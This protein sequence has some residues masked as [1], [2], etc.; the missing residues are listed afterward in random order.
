[1]TLTLER[2]QQFKIT[3]PLWIY[4]GA[5][6]AWHFFTIPQ[7]ESAQIKF[8]AADVKRG[9]GSVRVQVRIGMTEWRT[10]IFP[11]SK[12]QTYILPVKA[13]VRKKESLAEDSTYRFTLTI[14]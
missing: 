10:S 3:A 2:A 5:K 11:D 12:T 13:E 6:A 1:M 9:W 8:L 4:N 14:L 7:I